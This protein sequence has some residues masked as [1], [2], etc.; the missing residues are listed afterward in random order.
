MSTRLYFPSTGVCNI[1][2][3]FSGTSNGWALT[4]VAQRL[5][6]T[7][8]ASGTLMASTTSN[9]SSAV[10]NLLV[11]Q[12]ISPP[13]A[14]QTFAGSVSG[15]MRGSESNAAANASSAIGIRIVNSLGTTER[16]L[17]LPIT[18]GTL[19]YTTSLV[20]RFSPPKT[21]VIGSTSQAY[22]RLVIEVGGRKLAASTNRTVTLS[23]GDNST[24]LP[25]DESTTA[26]NNP[27]I[28]FSNN[29]SFLTEEYQQGLSRISANSSKTITGLSRIVGNVTRTITGL[30]RLSYNKSNL[31]SGISKIGILNTKSIVGKANITLAN[32]IYHVDGDIGSAAKKKDVQNV[33]DL[34]ETGAAAL[35]NANGIISPI[36]NGAYKYINTTNSGLSSDS[37]VNGVFSLEFWVKS[38]NLTGQARIFTTGAGTTSFQLGIGYTGGSA[39]IGRLQLDFNT[40]S[41]V[42]V[43]TASRIDDNKWH[44]IAVTYD[45]SG[46]DSIK[47]Y[48]DGILESLTTLVGTNNGTVSANITSWLIFTSTTKATLTLDEI[49]IS[50]SPLS[51][52]YISN[53][54]STVTK[55][56]ENQITG[57][58]R[59]SSNQLKTQTGLSRILG[60]SNFTITG[61]SRVSLNSNYNLTGK[62]RVSKNTN[63]SI[64][65]AARIVSSSKLTVTGLSRIQKNSIFAITGLGRVSQN[66]SYL[67]TGKSRIISNISFS[68]TA[69]SRIQKNIIYTL[70]S[71]SRIQKNTIKSITGISN[72]IAPPL[73]PTEVIGNTIV[74]IQD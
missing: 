57:L 40:G 9:Q 37:P 15:Q 24:D 2:I 56:I 70:N 67:I 66:S 42:F 32:S 73:A 47:I 18:T 23:H 61:K 8:S 3:P 74:W 46:T 49:K 29:I 39:P 27:W 28:E 11:R 65:A 44:Y 26:A 38:S 25:T 43:Y 14:A 34:T 55:D 12:Y 64:S 21:N 63:Y 69:L 52:S 41:E 62:S 53:Y 72:I 17:V 20:N 22:D 45:A 31:I 60:S 51:S 50:N 13:L 4:G 30:S 10:E 54:Y 16:G 59:I 71:I 35:T 58:S 6:L 5:Y 48:I 1:E 33:S 7:R 19:E 36:Q 68:T